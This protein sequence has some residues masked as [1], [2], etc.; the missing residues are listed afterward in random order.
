MSTR[1]DGVAAQT[2]RQQSSIDA[3]Y[4]RVEAAHLDGLSERLNS[5][6]DRAER[7]DRNATKLLDREL[8]QCNKGE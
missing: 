3:L 1:L 4:A 5:A 6:A 7:A 8:G 2:V